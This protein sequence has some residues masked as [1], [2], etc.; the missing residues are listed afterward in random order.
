M[1]FSL[2]QELLQLKLTKEE[3][4]IIDVADIDLEERSE[5]IALCLY[6]K[7]LTTKSFNHR[8]MKS[9][10]KNIWKPKRGVDFVLNDGPWCFDGKILLLT[11]VTGLEQPS[12]IQFVTT[13]FWVKAYNI[14]AKKQT[15]AYAQSIGL[16]IGKFV[17]RLDHV[18]LRCDSHKRLGDESLLQYGDWLR[19]SLLKSR[20][21]SAE[22][23]LREEKKLYLTFKHS[24][25]GGEARVKLHFDLPTPQSKRQTVIILNPHG[26][27]PSQMM[28]DSGS[29]VL[30]GNEVSKKKGEDVNLAENS[31]GKYE[32]LGNGGP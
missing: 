28:I 22:A 14:P 3:D 18:Y 10:L 23:K 26:E 29:P 15:I 8:A 7:L 31:G 32:N 2:E 30:E 21:R 20:R 27:S 12:E 17:G 19:A 11:E 16:K 25:G 4:E 1:A 24:N 6:G 9:I 13:R 5:Q